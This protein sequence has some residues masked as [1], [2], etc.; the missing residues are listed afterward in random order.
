MALNNKYVGL[1]DKEVLKSRNEYGSNELP[2]E[3]RIGFW[4]QFA[5]NFGDPI[6]KVLLAALAMNLLFTLKNFNWFESIGIVIAII[7]ATLVST[8]SEYGSE[9]AFDKLQK[10][11]SESVCRV[12]RNGK[13]VEIPV[14]ELVR[15]DIVYL[16]AG[17]MIPADGRLVGGAITVDQSSLNGESEDVKKYPTVS[18]VKNELSFPS[19]VFRGTLIR[20][21]QG[22]MQV[23]GV[24]ADTTY[25]SLAKGLR[26]TTR[27]S[28]LKLRLRALAGTISTI[29]YIAAAAVALAFFFNSVFIDSGFNRA[30]ILAR[31]S[32]FRF[33]SGCILHCLTLAVTIIVVCVPE[34]LPMMITVVLSANMKRMLS[35]NIM[36]RKLV[37]IET[38]GSM[39]IM[40]TDKTGTLT[41]GNQTVTSII[42]GDM[43]EISSF[44]KTQ[45]LR[46]IIARQAFCNSE[47][48][49]DRGK[50]IGGN[51]TDRALAAFAGEKGFY[52]SLHADVKSVVPFD[53]R[54]K[55]AAAEVSDGD[56]C[57]V[58]VKG[59][60]ELLLPN[61]VGY[62]DS[63][64]KIHNCRPDARLPQKLRSLA[65]ASYRVI[66]LAV[67]EKMP[68]K[69]SVGRLVL[70]ALAV[71]RDEI[72]HDAKKS[73]ETMRR[74]GIHVV[75]LTGDHKDTA[76]AIAERCGII[77][78]YRRGIVME[79]SELAGMSD[80]EVSAILPELAVVARALP[81]DKSRLVK[82]AQSRG[83]VV[84]MTGD[85]INDAPALK[86]ADVGFAMGSGTDIAREAGDI[87]LLDNNFAY[88][89][90]AVLYGRTIFKS[91]RKFIIFQL[92][93]NFCAVTVSLVGPFIGIDTPVTVI[94]ML[95][96]NIIMDTLGGLAFAGEP[97]VGSTMDEPP[98][99][100]DEPLVNKYMAKQIAFS[101]G[102]TVVVC[103]GFL[104]LPIVREFFGYAENPRPF[105]SAFF[106]LFIFLGVVN[107][108]I[109][110]TPRIN[111]ASHISGNKGFITI[112][113]AVTVIQLLMIYF[114]GNVFRAAPLS[115][116]RLLFVFGLSLLIIPFETVR[117]LILRMRSGYNCSI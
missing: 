33:M 55:Y 25:G 65:A 32:D 34:G 101:A 61:I 70:I 1:S 59:A 113:I 30:L 44:A 26:E 76:A 91:I 22:V 82:I 109:A 66:A 56:T 12:M 86:I 52:E 46:R 51:P 95:W 78:A 27:E 97:P 112:M 21:G 18:D 31:I 42:L 58:L 8:L 102:F 62:M 40:F 75:M 71:I 94:Q 14:V 77:G 29:G 57:S 68:D 92:T 19:A 81:D 74:A 2:K 3:K 93:M 16:F 47:C 98:K 35:D 13:T 49:Y 10:E 11:A 72:R 64:G 50:I 104:K 36:V 85:G 54:M 20:S 4:K 108:F 43:T 6:I 100:R 9:I 60:P 15:G 116:G 7:T 28:P 89:V 17:E 84:G 73:V 41:T 106:G 39:N 5:M 105:M 53:S 67:G 111:L 23:L 103:I 99:R 83:M 96:I 37:G 117:R 80:E 107:C 48:R 63:D 24:G 87:V 90:K 110:R 38:A 114:G 69:D 79:S 45:G 88:I 115:P